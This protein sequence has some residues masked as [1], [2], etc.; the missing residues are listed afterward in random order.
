MGCYN[1]YENPVC[2]FSTNSTIQKWGP[3]GHAHAEKFMKFSNDIESWE[4]LGYSYS[5]P[6]PLQ[7]PFQKENTMTRRGK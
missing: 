4:E 6:T 7:N 5:L 3:G 2:G 1:L